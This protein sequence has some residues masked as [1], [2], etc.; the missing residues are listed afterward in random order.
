MIPPY[1]VSRS[2]AAIVIRR[3][4]RAVFPFVADVENAARLRSDIV[5]ANRTSGTPAAPGATYRQIVKLGWRR[6]EV[7]V[8][9]TEYEPDRRL[10]FV[11]RKADR[12]TVRTTFNFR[13]H[14]IEQTRVTVAAKV[15]ARGGGRLA[16]HLERR[17]VEALREVK[18]AL[19]SGPVAS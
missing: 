8:E 12:M 9:N 15:E 4:V 11:A 17:E 2:E 16:R 6:L 18:R 3:P 1:Q 19:E 13:A 7:L 10:S 14:E 5:A